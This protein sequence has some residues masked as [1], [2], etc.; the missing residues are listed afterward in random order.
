MQSLRGA[1]GRVDL[2]K[3]VRVL[4]LD[5]G[6]GGTSPGVVDDFLDDALGVSVLLGVVQALE[7]NR[8]LPARS[9]CLEH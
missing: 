7:G 8:S 6:H 5:L 1:H 2:L 4:E 3:A 9:V